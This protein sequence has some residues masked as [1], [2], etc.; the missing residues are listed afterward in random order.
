MFARFAILTAVT[1]IALGSAASA[2]VK[3]Y[4][5]ADLTR[6]PA[7][8]YTKFIVRVPTEKPIPT[9]GLQVLVPAG[10]TVI[11][12]QPKAGGWHAAF[13]E[14]KGRIV[15]ITWT[16]GQIAPRE[17]DEFAILAAGPP[18]PVTVSWNALQT[19]S[20][21][22]VV[23]WT[24]PPGSETPHAQTVFTAPVGRCRRGDR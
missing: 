11:G 22:S 3:V 24:G 23:R 14:S 17:F 6:T 7:C 20:D 8:T 9:T 10:L 1:A 16:G 21:G 4:P 13:E 12:V 2:H 15:A 5:D 18:R 19:Y